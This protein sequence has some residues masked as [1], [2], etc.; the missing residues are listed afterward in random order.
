MEKEMYLKGSRG[1]NLKQN[2]LNAETSG[3]AT[4]FFGHEKIPSLKCLTVV[5]P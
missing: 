4:S 5:I 2:M 3:M 1:S